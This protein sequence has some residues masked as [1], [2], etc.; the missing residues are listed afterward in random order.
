[1]MEQSCEFI[2]WPAVFNL[3][4]EKS[5]FVSHFGGQV[6]VVV[7]TANQR[8]SATVATEKRP[9]L[10]GSRALLLR[11]AA[12][13]KKLWREVLVLMDHSL[14]LDGSVSN[15]FCLGWEGSATTKLRDHGGTFCICR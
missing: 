13:G 14:W 3:I 1:M 10:R 8:A 4:Y 12:I 2:L 15:S 5:Y 9:C 11:P 7:F 6:Y